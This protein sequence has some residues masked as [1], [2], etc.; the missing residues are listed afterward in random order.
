MYIFLPVK[1]V[2]NEE[3]TDWGAKGVIQDRKEND[4]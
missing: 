1:M 4:S 2:S 3:V